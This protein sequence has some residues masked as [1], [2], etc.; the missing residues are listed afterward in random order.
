MNESIIVLSILWIPDIIYVY[1]GLFCDYVFYFIFE[2][3]GSALA[4]VAANRE[5]PLGLRQISFRYL[6]FLNSMLVHKI[7]DDFLMVYL[8]CSLFYFF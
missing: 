2:G 1:L 6:C 7:N 4:N 3:F 8:S 5:L